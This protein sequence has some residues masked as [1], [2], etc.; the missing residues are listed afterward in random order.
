VALAGGL[1]AAIIMG[2]KCVVAT[3]AYEPWVLL[4]GSA[5]TGL[6][7]V[8]GIWGIFAQKE[9]TIDPKK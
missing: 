2:C 8:R 9:Q 5:V 1:V 4:T 7:S 3:G 6:V